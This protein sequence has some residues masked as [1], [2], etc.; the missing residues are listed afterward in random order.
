MEDLI[1]GIM[2]IKGVALLYHKMYFL[3][4]LCFF[5]CPAT[6]E[7]AT[8]NLD[9]AEPATPEGCCDD[10]EAGMHCQP[11]CVRNIQNDETALSSEVGFYWHFERDADGKPSGCPCFDNSEGWQNGKIALS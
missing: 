11:D 3:K 8:I 7:C 6:N 1:N 2:L 4:K 9:R 5:R 10:L